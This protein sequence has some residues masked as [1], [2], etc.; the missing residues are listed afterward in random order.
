M[1]VYSLLAANVIL[2][3]SAFGQA[4]ISTRSG[5]VHYFEG[6]VTV[7]GQPLEA[8]FGKFAAIPEG[9]EL[10]TVSTALA[11]TKA[12]LLSFSVNVAGTAAG[13]TRP[14]R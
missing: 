3:S 2:V 4:V 5:L 13:T 14:A 10:R 6:T 9:A 12:E 8:H 11:D 7:A 1:Y